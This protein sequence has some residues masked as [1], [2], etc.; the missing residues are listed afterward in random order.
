MHSLLVGAGISDRAIPGDDPV[1][2]A[3]TDGSL[4]YDVRD[5]RGEPERK[6][7]RYNTA[8]AYYLGHPA[9]FWVTAVRLPR[10]LGPLP[11]PSGRGAGHAELEHGD[12]KSTLEKE[13][14]QS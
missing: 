5:F 3:V 6:G 4:G 10:H 11:A 2:G 9:S 14:A 8:P 1:A 13:L 7:H 12:L